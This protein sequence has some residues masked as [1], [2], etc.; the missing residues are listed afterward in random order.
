MPPPLRRGGV[1]SY[2][3]EGTQW[4]VISPLKLLRSPHSV[5]KFL[6]FWFFFQDVPA[7]IGAATLTT[8]RSAIHGAL[9]PDLTRFVAVY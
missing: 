6:R 1:P 3:T 2:G 8:P 5:V 4:E 7:S 9:A